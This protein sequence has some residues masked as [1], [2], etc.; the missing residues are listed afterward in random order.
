MF[1]S[2]F[3]FTSKELNARQT[4]RQTDGWTDGQDANV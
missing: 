2:T 1:F 3:L 4:Y